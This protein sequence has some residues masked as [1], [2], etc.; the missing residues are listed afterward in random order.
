MA[1][2]VK[3]Q[4]TVQEIQ[5]TQIKSWAG[6]LSWGR[7]SQ[8]SPVFLPTESHGQR[9]LAGQSRLKLLSTHASLDKYVEGPQKDVL[10]FIT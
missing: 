2:V 5:E 4:L 8:P 6:K 10:D 7:K 1:L 3:N 9:S